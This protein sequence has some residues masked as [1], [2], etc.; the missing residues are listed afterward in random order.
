MVTPKSLGDG[1]KLLR[2]ALQAVQCLQPHGLHMPLPTFQPL[3]PT[4]FSVAS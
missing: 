2:T 1:V 3:E 4:M